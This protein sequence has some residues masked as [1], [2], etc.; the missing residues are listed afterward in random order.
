MSTS[1]NGSSRTRGPN[2]TTQDLR[3][4]AGARSEPAE[5]LTSLDRPVVP[6]HRSEEIAAETS[7]CPRG[8]RAPRE[9]TRDGPRRAGLPAAVASGARSLTTQ[10][11]PGVALI[12]TDDVRNHAVPNSE[13]LPAITQAGRSMPLLWL[14][15][16][17]DLGNLPGNEHLLDEFLTVPYPPAG[18]GDG[19]GAARD[20]RDLGL[21]EQCNEDCYIR[22][23]AFFAA[24]CVPVSCWLAPA[25][26]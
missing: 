4:R 19:G 11:G 9:T 13:A 26:H 10:P 23:S 6:Q 21:H 5:A 7:R 14:V 2:G 22:A 1:S 16:E 20:R 8:A 3:D 15:D 18:R 25:R 17:S 12:L 24:C